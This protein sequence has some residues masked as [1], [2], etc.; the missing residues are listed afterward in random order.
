M[1]VKI[2]IL[3]LFLFCDPCDPSLGPPE[4]VSPQRRYDIVKPQ[5]CQFALFFFLSSVISFCSVFSAP[6]LSLSSSASF[7]CI[8]SFSD[9][10]LLLFSFSFFL[11]LLYSLFFYSSH[12]YC[13]SPMLSIDIVLSINFYYLCPFFCSLVI[14]IEFLVSFVTFQ[15]IFC[16]ILF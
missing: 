4:D 3:I 5:F 11:L 15:D 16:S 10:Y 8:F 7:F 14:Q 2:P 1:A 9:N 6:L 13:T 12:I